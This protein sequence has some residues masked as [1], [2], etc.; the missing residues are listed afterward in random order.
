MIHHNIEFVKDLFKVTEVMKNLS[1]IISKDT[2]EYSKY[3]M[4][5]FS[6]TRQFPKS[7]KQGIRNK[8]EMELHVVK[9]YDAVTKDMTSIDGTIIKIKSITSKYIY[10]HIIEK[11]CVCASNRIVN[12][13]ENKYGAD[14]IWADANIYETSIETYSR[15]FQ[16][17]LT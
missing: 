9:E 2:K 14:F 6:L 11:M 3:I 1:D 5:W 7:W 12:V 15:A 10:S 16:F 4:M 13:L 8:P 17:I